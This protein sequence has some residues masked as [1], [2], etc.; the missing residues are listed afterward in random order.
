MAVFF[1][2]EPRVAYIADLVSPNKAG[3]VR[4][5]QGWAYC[6]RT[7]EQDLFLIYFEKDAP[8]AGLR[9]AKPGGIYEGK[10]FDPR[11]GAWSDSF[12]LTVDANG[13]AGVPKQPTDNDWALRVQ[14]VKCIFSGLI[15][16][17]PRATV[18][19]FFIL[20]P[21]TSVLVPLREPR[22]N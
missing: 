7:P 20:A 6:A 14:S 19:T 17:S 8:Q 15:R 4:D 9:G 18:A 1:I 10:W 16:P 13:R 2:R 5:Y 21:M 12:E 3:P 22:R 11:T